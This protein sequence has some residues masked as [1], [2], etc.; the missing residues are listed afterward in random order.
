M[1][2]PVAVVE[3]SLSPVVVVV[4]DVVTRRITAFIGGETDIESPYTDE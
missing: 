1:A 4:F 2:R 3:T